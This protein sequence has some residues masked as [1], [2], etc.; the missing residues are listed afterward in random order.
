MGMTSTLQGNSGMNENV[1]NILNSGRRDKTEIIAAIAAMTQKPA[2]I[3]HIMEHVNL[4]YSNLEY[5]KLMLRL[6]LLE[7]CKAEKS[8]GRAQ[9]FQAPEKRLSSFE[10]IS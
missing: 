4:S 6:R 3:T 7:T 2:K 5:I 10:D 9:V 8:N 1:K